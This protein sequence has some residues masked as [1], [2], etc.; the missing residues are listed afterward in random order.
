MPAMLRKVANV[1]RPGRGRLQVGA[2][3]YRRRE[4]G[5]FEI[6]L[7]T[8]RGTGRWMIPKGWPMIRKSY[9]EAAAQEAYEEA[10]VRGTANP[11]ELGRFD[12]EKS[13]FPESSLH[14]T[15]AVFPLP[16]E[17]EL[18]R[19]PERGQR[20]RRWFSIAEAAQAVQSPHLAKIIAAVEQRTA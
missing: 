16:V 7:V 3:P 1:V 20:T 5:T 14:C 15:I 18:E 11:V 9:A 12:H 13:R 8:T 2:L 4:D 19:W 17:E 6:L 10:G